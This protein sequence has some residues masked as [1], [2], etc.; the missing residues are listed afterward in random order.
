MITFVGKYENN[1][2]KYSDDVEAIKM[3]LVS[4]LNTPI[5]TR[6]YAP[7]YGSNIRNYRFS[8]L[9][10]FTISMIGQE[11]KNAIQFMSGVTLA[12]ISYEVDN[13][14]L[15]F[16]IDLYYLSEIVRVNLTVVD[17]VAS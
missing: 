7:T 5:G 4:I 16:T 17:G 12:N 14:K 2:F 8:I 11:I 9:N 3:Q 6:F 15:L 1:N 10:Y 13:N